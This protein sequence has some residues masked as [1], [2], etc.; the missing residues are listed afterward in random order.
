MNYYKAKACAQAQK[1]ECALQFL[2]KS[3]NQGFTD[4][5]KISRDWSFAY[6]RGNPDFERLIARQSQP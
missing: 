5:E 3:L 6:L 2:E 4:P 1:N